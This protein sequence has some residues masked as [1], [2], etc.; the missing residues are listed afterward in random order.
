VLVA[1]DRV[2]PQM[3]GPGIRYAELARIL[4]RSH[5]VTLA[6]PVGSTELPAFPPLRVYDP[7]HPASLRRLLA[8]AEVVVA[9]PLGPALALGLSHGRRRWIADLYNPEPF[10]GLHAHP[11]AGRAQLRI[12]DALRIDRLTYAARS[13]D[14]FI[15]AGER[16]RA[17]WLG[18]LAASRRV[19]SRAHAGDP[20]LLRLIAVVASGVPD[21]PPV[22]P[23]GPT[24]RGSAL[25]ADAL[26]AVWNGGVWPWLDLRTTVDAISRLR[27][28]DPRW[29]LVI[30]GAGRP[31]RAS[32]AGDAL[33]DAYARLGDS[34]LHVVASWTDYDH[35]G[36][37]LLE[38]DVG[39]CTH[40]AGVESSM[41]E[42]VRV[43]DLLW[44]GV[45]V[46]CSAGDPIAELVSLHGLGRVVAP[47]DSDALARALAEIADTGR[48]AFAL[49][50]ARAA[51]ARRWSVTA[52]PLLAL[53]DRDD[54]VRLRPGLVARS[55]AARH[56]VAA[57][58]QR[59]LSR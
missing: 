44:A 45:P 19:T 28:G 9:P 25:P 14:A 8:D 58:A 4:S 21:E 7:A 50:L 22:A 10:E 12:L 39:V 2:G 29:V 41:A 40:L 55:L 56:R 27:A 53:I 49:A 16:Q 11:A 33:Q 48:A 59:A 35:R 52:A 18:Y 57:A 24:L 17:M 38:A 37:V 26:I 3:A 42:R 32:F 5:D 23:P 34:G 30:T 31:G 6:A 36:D 51:A 46:A 20:E 15:C 1:P 54:G 47:G 43:L 13:A